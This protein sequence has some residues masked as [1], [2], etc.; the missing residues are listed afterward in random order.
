MEGYKAWEMSSLSSHLP[1]PPFL[2]QIL[3]KDSVTVTVDAV[4]YFRIQDAC[5]SV[6]NVDNVKTATRLLAQTTL[7]SVVSVTFVLHVIRHNQ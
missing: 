5:S 6:C 7:R 3:T 1:L 4:V 2:S